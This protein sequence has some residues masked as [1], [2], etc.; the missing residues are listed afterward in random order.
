[1]ASD[2]EFVESTLERVSE[3]SE[4]VDVCLQ[5]SGTILEDLTVTVVVNTQTSTAIGE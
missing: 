3:A 2:V 4:L 1:M 5:A